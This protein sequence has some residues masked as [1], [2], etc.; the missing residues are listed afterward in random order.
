[1]RLINRPLKPRRHPMIAHRL[2]T[3]KYASWRAFLTDAHPE[4]RTVVLVMACAAIVV[5]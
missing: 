1:M 3:E 4:I 5:P 2:D